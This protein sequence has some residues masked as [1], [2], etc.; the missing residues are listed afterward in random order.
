MTYMPQDRPIRERERAPRRQRPAQS[1]QKPTRKARILIGNP[2]K[3]AFAIKIGSLYHDFD[4]RKL[5][6]VPCGGA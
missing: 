4:I 5:F 3:A 1:E 6:C 2:R